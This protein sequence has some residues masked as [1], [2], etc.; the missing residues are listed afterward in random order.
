VVADASTNSLII[1]AKAQEYKQIEEVI[2][3]LDVMPRQV[4][5]DA[6]IAEISLDGALQYGLQWF[7]RSNP[8]YAAL[9]AGTNLAE[10]LSTTAFP[11]AG[12]AYIFSSNQVKV[13]LQA[14][15]RQNKVNVL[16]SP[17]LMVLNNQEG[18]INVGDQVP[19]TT[20]QVTSALGAGLGAVNSIQYRDTGVILS[21]RPRVN[22]GGLVTLDVSQQVSQPTKTETSNLDSPTIQQRQIK[23]TVVVKDHDTIALGGLI[24]DQRSQSVNGI[25][26]LS[27]VPI[28]GPLFGTYGREMK[29]TELVVLLTPRVV[30]DRSKSIS[31]TNEYRGSLK[32]L[33]KSRGLYNPNVVPKVDQD[34]YSTTP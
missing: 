23:T 32:S 27:T 9:G 33:Y 6:T 22:A 8:S 19:I 2:K 18:Q 34:E 30:E 20:G 12:F 28:I 25:P 29:R 21:V 5:I 11:A 3:E 4:L 1:V 31:I 16:S 24:R 7:I 13:L 15:A 10:Q 17:S 26:W 14:L